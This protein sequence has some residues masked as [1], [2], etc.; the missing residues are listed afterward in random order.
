MFEPLLGHTLNTDYSL[1]NP[2][3]LRECIAQYWFGYSGISG[4][5][6]LFHLY[7]L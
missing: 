7:R 1:S 5:F 4:D 6:S 3:S 2:D